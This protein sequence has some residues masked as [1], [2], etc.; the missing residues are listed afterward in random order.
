MSAAKH[1]PG[2]LEVG[3]YVPTARFLAVREHVAVMK[4]GGE[5]I[6][7]TGSSNNDEK[8]QSLADARLYA[9]APDLLAACEALLRTDEVSDLRFCPEKDAAYAAIA[10]ARGGT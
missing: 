5:L 2:P 10:K 9:A 3:F 1:S 4:P 6:A 7:L 8:D